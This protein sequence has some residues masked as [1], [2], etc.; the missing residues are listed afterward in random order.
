MYLI[1]V[2]NHR[3]F[4]EPVVQQAATTSLLDLWLEAY[5]RNKW[6]VIEVTYLK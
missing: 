2:K 5:H 4:S 6:E 1:T 3:R